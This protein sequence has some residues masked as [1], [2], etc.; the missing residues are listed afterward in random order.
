MTTPPSFGGRL[1]GIFEPAQLMTWAMSHYI[2]VCA[3]AIFKEG[4][5]LAPIFQ[6]QQLRD[7]AFGRFWVE[8][9]KEES[10]TS[11]P[12]KKVNGS[13]DLLP[14][15]LRTA[16]GIVLDIGPGTGTQMPLLRS[17]SIK[18]IYGA[19]PCRG[20]HEKL[21]LRAEA[22]GLSSKYHILPSGAAASELLPALRATGTGITD[23]Y[24]LD[25]KKGIFDTIL[26]VRV[27]CSVPEMQ[28][29]VD[30]LY[31]LLKPGGKILVAEHVVNPWRT[32]KGSLLA[33]AMQGVY[34]V[35]GWSFFSA[36][37][38]LNRD[39]EGALLRA[40]ERD[41]GWEIVD[42]ERHFS[43]SVMPYVSGSLVKRG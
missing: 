43:W 23:A 9:S 35:L 36:D 39:T 33:R 40:A 29:T 19:E 14:P 13:S 5:I 27:L 4:K 12:G 34:Q 7:K 31:G 28:R 11:K 25:A 30:E 15:L 32:A 1:K 38:A 2:R 41:G 16:S 3:E 26:C 6:I 42:L 24:D 22:E 10:S 17:Q 20:L 37:C 21:Q 8:F 18:T